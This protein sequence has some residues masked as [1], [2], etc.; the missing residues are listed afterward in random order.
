MN[1]EKTEKERNELLTVSEIVRNWLHMYAKKIV[2]KEDAE[3]IIQD[4]FTELLVE[5]ERLENI[6]SLSAYLLR[7]VRNRCLKFLD[8][9]RHKYV[10]YSIDENEI[11][12]GLEND[13]P[14]TILILEETRSAIE[15]ALD[16][17]PEKQRLVLNLWI[18]GSSDKEIAKILKI[19]KNTVRTHWK[20]AISTLRITLRSQKK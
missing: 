20:R 1:E 9:S 2:N 13:D 7:S 17:L 8:L 11:F 3:D 6:K 19:S 10:I 18:E 15:K 12:S 14:L 4:L 16:N 5:R